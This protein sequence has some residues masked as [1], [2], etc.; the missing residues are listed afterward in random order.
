MLR[1]TIELRT[2]IELHPFGL[3][4]D[5]RTLATVL[6]GL[7]KINRTTNVGHY[8]SR[9]E[10]DQEGPRPPRELVYLTHDRNKGAVELVR[11]ALI[12]HLKP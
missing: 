7:Q 6:I 9:I 10:T 2:T 11:A 8:A 4:D 5:K 12:E 3:E 1:A